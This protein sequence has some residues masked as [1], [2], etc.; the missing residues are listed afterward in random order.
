MERG[1][2][3]SVVDWTPSEGKPRIHTGTVIEET[4]EALRDQDC[5]WRGTEQ[6]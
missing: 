3:T 2:G 5:L 6:P 4:E 1:N